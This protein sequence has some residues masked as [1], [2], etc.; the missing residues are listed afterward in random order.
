MSCALGALVQQDGQGLVFAAHRLHGMV[1]H[2]DF[3]P[4]SEAAARLE[5]LARQADFV[6]AKDA[7]GHV[8]AELAVLDAALDSWQQSR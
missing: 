2:F 3:P 4:L 7:Y 5:E 1:S 6:A 8:E